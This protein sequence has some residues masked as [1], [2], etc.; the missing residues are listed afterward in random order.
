MSR[1]AGRDLMKKRILFLSDIDSAHT[2]KWA[3]SLAERGYIIGIFSIRK[4][5]TDWFKEFP[6]IHVFDREG[7]GTERFHA[8]MAQKLSYLK[9]VPFLKK[10]LRAFQPDLVHAHYATSYGLLGV[11]SGFHPLIISVWGSDI[12]EFP[13]KSILHRLLVFNNLKNADAIFSTSEIMKREVLNYVN[14]DVAVTPFGVDTKIFQP[15][16]V[17][18]LFSEG[19]KVI[20]VIKSLEPAYA[21]DVLIKAFVLVKKQFS[22]EVKLLICGDGTREAEL[23]TI[24]ASTEF[25]SEIIF[26]GKI[27]P[28]EVP[29]YH[30]MI[31]IFANISLQESFGVAVVEAMACEKPVIAT[32]VGG[33]KEVVEENVTGIFVPPA[34]VEKTADAILTLLRDPEKAKQMGKAGRERVLE[35][36]DWNKNLDTVENLYTKLF[37]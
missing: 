3:I 9:L 6:A 19:T 25:S 33:L 8:G 15:L 11:R 18:S 37:F 24:A 35:K 27:S 12:F 23:K 28:N 22:G 2:R 10:V 32:A 29:R 30:N 4:S 5:E 17:D 14:R 31:D 16:E 1:S 21:I 20:G 13:R 26:A 36:Y 7:F 34:D